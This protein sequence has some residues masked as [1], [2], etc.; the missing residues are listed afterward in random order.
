MRL[1][2]DMSAKNGYF[3]LST[4]DPDESPKRAQ[5]PLSA[6][7]Q[8]VRPEPRPSVLPK[9]R[10]PAPLEH[11][12]ENDEMIEMVKIKPRRNKHRKPKSP[13]TK[14]PKQE[15]IVE[16]LLPEDSLQRVSL[17]YGCPVSSLLVLKQIVFVTLH[18]SS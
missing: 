11:R 12:S 1:L 17:R 10:R 5:I 15:L 3:R 14:R 8:D 16:P 13:S 2:N 6:H 9:H 7:Q 18:C 4:I